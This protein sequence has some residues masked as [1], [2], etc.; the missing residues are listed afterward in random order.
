[1]IDSKLRIDL[2]L[3]GVRAM[4]GTV[5]VFHGSQKLFGAFGGYGLEGTAGWMASIGIPFADLS[6]LLAGSTEF[7]G[8]LAL[9]VGLAT[10]VVSVPLLF[11]MVVAAFTAHTGFNAATGGMEYPLVL[12][13]ISGALALAGAGRFSADARIPWDRLLPGKL[14]STS[15]SVETAQA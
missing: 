1:M 10:R 13:A 15:P 4:V 9:V 3:V 5:F 6:A 11:T 7:F 8:G 2:A 12:A 14:G